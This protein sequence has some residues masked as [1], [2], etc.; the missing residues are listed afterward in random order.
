MEKSIE[1]DFYNY[2]G[3]YKKPYEVLVEYYEEKGIELKSE[4]DELEIRIKKNKRK[5]K[6]Y[7]QKMISFS[8]VYVIVMLF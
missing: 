8:I 7:K 2:N 5:I 6:S 3:T 4:M 1:K